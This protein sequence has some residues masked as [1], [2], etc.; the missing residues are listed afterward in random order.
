MQSKTEL[1]QKLIMEIN[2]CKKCDLWKTRKNPV[3]GEGD[4]NALTVFIGEAPGY[5]EDLMG[6]PFVGAAGKLLEEILEEN[7]FSRERVYITNVVKCR[8]PRNREPKPDEIEAC[9][10]YLDQQL[11]IIKPKIIVTLGR[12]S[13]I[14]LFSK[15]G[16]I[17][18][19]MRA[20]Q[21]KIYRV[22][23]LG[24]P[25]YLIVSYHPAAALYNPKLRK[26][27]EDSIRLT[28]DVER[29]LKNEVFNSEKH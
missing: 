9:S 17:F 21:G 19:S 26:Y 23:L 5:W 28:R 2:N 15:A 22:K 16:L 27:I 6:K 1:M 20:N 7:G 4:V 8:P 25:I 12:H 29:K 3:P 11:N 14:Y 10:P 24:S 18:K 13:T